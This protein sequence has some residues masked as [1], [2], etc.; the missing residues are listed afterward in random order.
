MVSIRMPVPGL[1]S[2]SHSWQQRVDLEGT[3]L[4]P[5]ALKRPHFIIKRTDMRYMYNKFMTGLRQHSAYKNIPV[6]NH[7]S[8]RRTAN[9]PEKGSRLSQLAQQ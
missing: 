4:S 6:T 3:T 9:L 1:R 7:L 5:R 8:P 2:A